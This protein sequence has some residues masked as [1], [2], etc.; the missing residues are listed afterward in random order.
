MSQLLSVVFKPIVFILCLSPLAALAWGFYYNELGAN[1]FEVLTRDTGE[2]TLRFLLL[3]L[4]MTP[5]KRLTASAWPL[6]FR[7]MLGLF[8]FFYVCVHLLTYIWLDHFFDWEEIFTDILKR[9]YITFGML[10]FILLIP[11]ALT[12]N[13]YMI[14]RLGKRWKSLHKLVYLIAVLGLL[15]FILLVKADLKEPIFYFILL[16]ALFVMRSKWFISRQW[17]INPP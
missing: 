11:L 15:H 4:F 8:A 5:L 7:R 10:A 17:R 1:P 12:S 9:P 2:W 14:K 16:L 6:R 3:T 13:K